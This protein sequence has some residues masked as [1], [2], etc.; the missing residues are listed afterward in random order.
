MSRSNSTGASAISNTS[1]GIA[2]GVT[3]APLSYAFCTE[4]PLETTSIRREVLIPAGEVMHVAE[5]RLGAP[6]GEVMLASALMKAIKAATLEDTELRRK[7]VAS[8]ISM[9]VKRPVDAGDDFELPSEDEVSDMIDAISLTPG[10]V[11]ELPY[12]YDITPFEPKDE[13]ANFQNAMKWQLTA[14]CAAIGIMPHEVLFDFTFT[15]RLGR[16]MNL[17][18]ERRAS[19]VHRTLEYQVGDPICRWFVD[20]AIASGRFVPPADAAS[21][22]L[23]KHDWEWDL[24]PLAAFNQELA[25]LQKAKEDG[26]DH[27]RL[28]PEDHVPTRPDAGRDREGAG[29]G[30]ETAYSPRGRSSSTPKPTRRSRPNWRLGTDR[31]TQD[32][33]N[34]SLRVDDGLS[35]TTFGRSRAPDIKRMGRTIPRNPM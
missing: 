22:D 24:T 5:R 35:T 2:R 13:P 1:A 18:Q 7:M 26:V 14:I 16:L 25:A 34:F 27:R 17:I 10:G 12:G 4:H 33:K 20:I 30:R 19:V 6:R 21:S 11:F 9:V 15:E 23:Y 29:G 3:G 28:H 31:F 32:R 8:L